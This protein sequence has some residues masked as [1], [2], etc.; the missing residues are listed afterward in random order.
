MCLDFG[1]SL[2]LLEKVEVVYDGLDEGLL[3]ITVNHTGGLRSLGAVTDS[4]LTDL[5]GTGC[6]EAAKVESLAHSGDGLGKSRLATNLLALLL[7]LGIGLEAGKT[8]LKGDGDGENG[9]A[10]RVSLDP[11]NNLGQV[12]VLLTEVVS[13]AKVGQVDNRLGGKKEE[14]VDDLDLSNLV[15]HEHERSI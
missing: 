2:Q 7:D 14:R 3:E 10:R 4:P 13:L 15:S 8:L 11:L 5:I 9:L 6:E 12:L 1:F